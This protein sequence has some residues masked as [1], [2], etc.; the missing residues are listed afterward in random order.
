MTREMSVTD[1]VW[2][3]CTPEVAYDAVS[4]L[5]RMPTW[6]PE[7]TGA[8]VPLGHVPSVG[9]TFVGSNKRGPFRWKTRC[10]VTAAERGEVF[11]FRAGRWGVGAPVL[12]IGI[13]AWEYRFEPV[14]GGTC[15]HETWTDER[16]GIVA[17]RAFDRLATG[18]AS[19]A[20]FQRGNIRRTL[21]NL[22]A[23][24]EAGGR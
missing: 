24:L 15:V 5:A 11:A 9:M 4:D 21:R 20:D 19:F 6:S 7:N 10:E 14:D 16:P 2:I 17:T 22:K 13:A 12:P 18:A 1:S 23:A 8:N 3:D